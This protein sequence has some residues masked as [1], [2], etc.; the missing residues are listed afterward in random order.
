[1]PQDTRGENAKC[2]TFLV[3]TPSAPDK[4]QLLGGS[5]ERVLSRGAVGTTLNPKPLLILLIHAQQ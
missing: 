2:P 1:M 5:Y 4:K 3:K